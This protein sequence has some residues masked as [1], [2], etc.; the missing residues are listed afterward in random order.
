MRSNTVMCVFTNRSMIKLSA[1]MDISV[2]G[3][4][5]R[6]HCN[7][8]NAAVLGGGIQFDGLIMHLCDKILRVVLI[9]IVLPRQQVSPCMYEYTERTHLLFENQHISK[10][11]VFCVWR[12]RNKANKYCS[13]PFFYV[14]FTII[15]LNAFL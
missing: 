11:R 13:N 10:V 9:R 12:K 3:H 14:V 1:C 6:V 5:Y 7:S 8:T 4:W 2:Y 15:P